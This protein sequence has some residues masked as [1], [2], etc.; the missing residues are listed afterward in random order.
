MTITNR[1]AA[2]LGLRLLALLILV[3]W[4]F[5]LPETVAYLALPAAGTPPGGSFYLAVT[6]VLLLPPVLAGLLWFGVG[7]M[8]DIVLPIRTAQGRS[9]RLGNYQAQVIAYSAVGLFLLL[10]GLPELA[11]TVH[12]VWAYR[13][14]MSEM[15]GFHSGLWAALLAAVLRLLLGATL[16]L[17]APAVAI[18]IQRL[19]RAGARR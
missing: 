16:I 14:K 2:V 19:R 12:G 5:Q 11:R 9:P 17:R 7:R 3:W 10:G 6:L 18:L 1:G 4:L 8:A 13:L 15:P